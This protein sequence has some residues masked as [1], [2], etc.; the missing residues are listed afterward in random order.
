[1]PSKDRSFHHLFLYQDELSPLT[2]SKHSAGNNK[3]IHDKEIRICSTTCLQKN[4]ICY[5]Y[6]H[7][8]ELTGIL[9]QINDVKNAGCF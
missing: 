8:H 5:S 6:C 2:V 9:Q 3:L 1:M 7:A 4:R